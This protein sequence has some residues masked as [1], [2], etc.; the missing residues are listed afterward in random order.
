MSQSSS[1]P[2]SPAGVPPRR[3]FA[4]T[5]THG[6]L[7]LLFVELAGL[8]VLVPGYLDPGSLLDTSRTFIETGILALGMTFVIVSGGI[9]LSVASLLALV[10]VVLGLSYQAG[11]PLPVSMLLGVATGVGGGLINGAAIAYLGLHPFV[12]TLATMAIYRGAA[13]AISNA[14]A[15]S[16]FPPWFTNIGQSYFGGGYVPIQLPVLII[17]ALSCWLLLDRTSFGRRVYGIGAN[18]LATRFSGVPV[19]RVK[20]AIYGLMGGLVS[21]AAIVQTARV[22]TARANASIGLELPVIAMVVLGGTKITGGAGTI[23]G[24]MLGVLVLAYLQDGLAS[25]GVRN[26]WGLVIVGSFLIVGVLANEFF[27]RAP[28]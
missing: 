20:L 1:R 23:G 15:V 26:D 6:L 21:V 8:G 16:D 14:A 2:T 22:S 12:V 3:S 4:F 27:R 18:E 5:R 28:R 17:A 9:D 25:A 19:E 24:T 11:L 10:S 7:L 13:Y